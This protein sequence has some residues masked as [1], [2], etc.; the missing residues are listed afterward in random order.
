M[1]KKDGRGAPDNK[2]RKLNK[3]D[4]FLDYKIEGQIIDL[5]TFLTEEIATLKKGS[6]IS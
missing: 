2:K 3:D 6:Q 5:S 1:E 4:I